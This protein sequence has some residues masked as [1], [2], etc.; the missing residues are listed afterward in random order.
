MFP[1]NKRDNIQRLFDRYRLS[2]NNSVKSVRNLGDVLIY[3]LKIC[4]PDRSW[5]AAAPYVL[6]FSSFS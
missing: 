5:F 1:N 6:N 3:P 4:Y 2:D